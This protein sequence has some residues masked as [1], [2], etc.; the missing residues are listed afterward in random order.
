MKR[1][2]SPQSGRFTTRKLRLHPEILRTLSALTEHDLRHVAGGSAL[3]G[4]SSCFAYE[5][6]ELMP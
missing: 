6:P 4:H 2:T 5:C 1:T 3:S